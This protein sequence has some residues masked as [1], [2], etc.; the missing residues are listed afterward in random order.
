MHLT[1]MLESLYL[2][3][4]MDPCDLQ[5]KAWVEEG[6]VDPST[7]V[8]VQVVGPLALVEDL[9]VLRVDPSVLVEDPGVQGVDPSDQGV[10]GV[11]PSDQGASLLTLEVVVR[12]VDL[13][14]P[15]GVL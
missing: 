8:A 6:Q 12:E 10:Q 13:S 9:G 1:A 2:S 15:L 5:L 4:E 11:D 3:D 14:D 7:L